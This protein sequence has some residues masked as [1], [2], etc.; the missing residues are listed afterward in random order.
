MGGICLFIGLITFDQRDAQAWITLMA[1]RKSLWRQMGYEFIDAVCQR[2]G[3]GINFLM[4]HL[5]WLY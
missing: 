3:D 5:L 2:Q 1:I 4:G